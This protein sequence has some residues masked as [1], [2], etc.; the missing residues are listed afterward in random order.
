LFRY[1]NCLQ[2][3]I[4]FYIFLHADIAELMDLKEKLLEE[5]E[6]TYGSR[7]PNT[8]RFGSTS[9][10]EIAD[11][12]CLSNSLLTKLLSGTATQGMYERCLNNLE[13]INIA[14]KLESE[15]A[16]LK[17]EADKKGSFSPMRML[18]FILPVVGVIA[19]FQIYKND[20]LLNSSTFSYD[21]SQEQF[22]EKFFNPDFNTPNFLPYVPTNKVQEYCPCSAY[23]GEWILNKPYTI[24]IPINQPGL[25]YVARSSKIKLKCSS[26]EPD[27]T[28]GKKMHGFEI[29]SHE[30]WMDTEHE[31]LVPKFFNT[32][33]KQFTKDFFNID[34]END[35][36][37][38]KV[39]DITSFF[40]NNIF[41]ND[42]RIIREGEP[43]GRYAS[44]MNE[45]ALS[46]YK[47]DLKEILNHVV[48]DMIK[49]E[50]HDI[51]NPYCNPNEL[52][53]GES[54]LEFKCDFS[55][56]S[57]NLGIGGNY[58]YTKGYRLID[59]HYSHNLLCNCLD[60]DYE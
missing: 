35:P 24:P 52:V 21:N 48:G 3:F 43:C 15:N 51:P 7:N 37:Y 59:Q 14:N 44:Y 47:I 30:F 11:Q 20:S 5:L 46:K 45:E 29:L 39:A 41:I 54:L 50:C 38:E 25:Y 40:Y 31:P 49:V 56:R 16:T 8:S 13:R 9:L 18:L 17:A 1:Y 27:E 33:K 32:Q 23:E 58:P 10:G 55:I 42:K 19:L 22:L 34:F 2:Y 53:E 57:E 6:L 4:L 60:S 12:L 28:K 26:S 36:R